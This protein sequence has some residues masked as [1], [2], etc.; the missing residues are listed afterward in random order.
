MPQILSRWSFDLHNFEEGSKEMK[1]PV[2][3]RRFSC[4]AHACSDYTT[5][6]KCILKGPDKWKKLWIR[7]IGAGGETYQLLRLAML[8]IEKNSNFDG[9]L[10]LQLRCTRFCPNIHNFAHRNRQICPRFCIKLNSYKQESERSF[11][12]RP[13]N[14]KKSRPISRKNS[15]QA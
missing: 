3:R 4:S 11:N 2:A 9:S 10:S 5:V 15:L 12:L 8:S 1:R 14:W 13:P 7:K 6:Q